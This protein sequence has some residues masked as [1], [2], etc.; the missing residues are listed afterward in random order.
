MRRNEELEAFTGLA[1]TMTQTLE[2]AP[3]VEQGARGAAPRRS[4]EQLGAAH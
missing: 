4:R 3:I 1:T 2:E